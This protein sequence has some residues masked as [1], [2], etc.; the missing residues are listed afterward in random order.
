M[1]V[2]VVVCVVVAV[3]VIVVAGCVVVVGG[4]VVGGGGCWT[5][6]LGAVVG[7]VVGGGGC[8]TGGLAVVGAVVVDAA[9][10]DEG[11]VVCDDDVVVADGDDV[12]VVS[13]D[14]VVDV[15][16]PGSTIAGTGIIGGGAP[17]DNVA[18]ASLA[19]TFTDRSCHW[20]TRSCL[21]PTSLTVATVVVRVCSLSWA[22][23]H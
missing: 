4:G 9:V 21:R 13:D 19:S 14:V 18:F 1:V 16:D 7:G 11:V 15:V 2:V 3:V 23:S 17:G 12:V 8:W 10:S 6:G 5:G 22:A 20:E